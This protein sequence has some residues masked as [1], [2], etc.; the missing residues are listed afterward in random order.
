M[1]AHQSTDGSTPKHSFD[2]LEHH[3]VM[4]LPHRAAI[5][6]WQHTKALFRHPCTPSCCGAARQRNGNA[7]APSQ[8]NSRTASWGGFPPGRRIAPYTAKSGRGFTR[9]KKT[10]FSF[11]PLRGRDLHNHRSSCVNSF[12]HAHALS[13]DGNPLFNVNLVLSLRTVSHLAMH[14]WSKCVMLIRCILDAVRIVYH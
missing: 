8:P 13:G 6:A 2:I 4:G 1:A 14:G 9:P 5:A 11:S 12:W 3:L 7:S 10:A